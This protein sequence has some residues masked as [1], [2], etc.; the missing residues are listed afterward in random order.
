MTNRFMAEALNEAR[1]ALDE[2]EVP[3]GAVIVK[4]GEIIA[5]GHNQREKL[6]D[7][8][9]HAE[10]VAIREA[11]GNIS[12]WRLDGCDIYVTLE[13]CAM[14]AGAIINSRMRRLFFGAY[15]AEYGASGGRIDLFSRAYFGAKT[16]VYGGIMEKEC[17]DFINAFFASIRKKSL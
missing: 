7:A 11:C 3:I 12:D 10:M 9:L 1:A 2:G 4:D 8:T 17:T 14:C 15:D 6:R 16:E 5:R 13:P